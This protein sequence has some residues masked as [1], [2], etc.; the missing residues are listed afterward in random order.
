MSQIPKSK[1]SWKDALLSSGMPLEHSVKE[2]LKELGI[3]SPSE[4]AY[5]RK[6]ETGLPKLFS[7]D[8]HGTRQKKKELAIELLIECKYRRDNTDW[9]FSPDTP[10][11]AYLKNRTPFPIVNVLRN[12]IS[13]SPK[14]LEALIGNFKFCSRGVEMKDGRSMGPLLGS[15][16]TI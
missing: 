13:I 7:I 12:D 6:C 16:L 3:I 4:F 1:R 8:V 9:I 15:V 2:D 14:H 10:H 11:P 5:N